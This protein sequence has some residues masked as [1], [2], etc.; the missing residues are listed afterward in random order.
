MQLSECRCRV[1]LKNLPVC[2]SGN[3]FEDA[4]HYLMEC[5][6][7]TR[8]RIILFDKL[9]NFEPLSVVKLLFDDFN[10]NFNDKKTIL[11]SQQE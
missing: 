9:R 3:P 4:D 7:Y 11:L 10:L 1:N 6:I 5:P 8:Y 2:N